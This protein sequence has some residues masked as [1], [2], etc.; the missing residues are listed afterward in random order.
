VL[1][2]ADL[3]GLG[4]PK[5]R[6]AA[7]RGLAAAVAAGELDLDAPAR[8][9]EALERLRAIPGVG[10]WTAEYVALRALGEPD[11]FPATDLGLRRALGPP[12]RPLA[13][14]ALERQAEAWR[15]WRAYAAMALWTVE[16]PRR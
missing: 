13:A 1:A 6:A 7:I 2:G 15:P 3:A 10:P 8:P 9:A 16:P 11:A 14:R 4:L 5:A 12:G